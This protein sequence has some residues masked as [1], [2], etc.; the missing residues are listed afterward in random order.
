MACNCITQEQLESL[1]KAFGDKVE[2]TNKKKTFKKQLQLLCVKICILLLTPILFIF[3]L[4]KIF[5][6]N[7]KIN[8]SDFF[9]LDK[10]RSINLSDYVREQ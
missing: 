2:K 1:Y 4:Y 7:G 5:F 3:I 10:E 6:K 9:G 8:I